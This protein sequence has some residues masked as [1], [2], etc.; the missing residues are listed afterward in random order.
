M[1]FET[2]HSS[3]L[4][5]EKQIT[6]KET[7]E[8]VFDFLEQTKFLEIRR[9]DEKF[10]NWL[11]NISYEEYKN[12]L[13]RLNGIVREVPIKERKIDGASVEISIGGT[14]DTVYL[15]PQEEKKDELMS[16]TFEAFKKIPN[17][18]DKALLSYYS[19]QAIHPFS[20][21]NGRLGR[22]LYSLISEDGKFV[23]KD[24][25]SDIVNHNEDGRKGIAEGRN[26][27][28]EKIL[29]PKE[30]YNLINRELIKEY[31][32]EEF[33]K[34]YGKIY[35]S[36]TIGVGNIP[37]DLKLSKQEKQLAEKIL[38]E[39]DI[40]NFQF[41]SIVILKLLKENDRLR[42]CQ[43]ETEC[44][45][46]DEELVSMGDGKKIL[47]IDNEKFENGLTEQD[48]K[49]VIEIHKEVKEKFIQ[50][51]IDIFENPERHKVKR[52]EKEVLI[53]ELFHLLPKQ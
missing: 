11:Q 28:A 50:I 41:N 45:M 4:A 16:K 22:L 34:E 29:E 52:N 25:L 39:G 18:N 37:E 32:G 12:Y 2:F 30:S 20:D 10:N 49:R 26:I 21:G 19:I 7:G 36:G 43:Y 42:E 8:K 46:D 40:K 53:K 47:G 3:E 38:G 33:L 14:G 27:F 6:K 23:T 15:P 1:T 13:T 31:F 48:I 35:Y 9:S 17:L 51:M 24:N 44:L 5:E